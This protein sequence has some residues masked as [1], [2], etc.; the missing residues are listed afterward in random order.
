MAVSIVRRYEWWKSRS[1]TADT[2]GGIYVPPLRTMMVSMSRH[3]NWST[4]GL[5]ALRGCISKVSTPGTCTTLDT[6]QNLR[7]S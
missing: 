6:R 5:A 3:Q 4:A 2:N 7:K 1:A